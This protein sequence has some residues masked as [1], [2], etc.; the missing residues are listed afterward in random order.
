MNYLGMHLTNISVRSTLQWSVP[1]ALHFRDCCG[2]NL[3]WTSVDVHCNPYLVSV[4]SIQIREFA[5]A[6]LNF[7]PANG[8][9]H[10]N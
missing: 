5:E 10:G 9:V 3:C 4:H 6:P 2:R 8:L 1:K 7:D